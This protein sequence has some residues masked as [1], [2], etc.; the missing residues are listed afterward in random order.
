[1]TA[2]SILLLALV[3]LRLRESLPRESRSSM[4]PVYL[5][6]TYF[7]VS[8]HARF[9]LI[10]LSSSMFFGGF[11]L[12]I[13]SAPTMVYEH[14]GLGPNDFGYLFAMLVV[15]IM[16]GSRLS[17]QLAGI[18]NPR[19]QIGIGFGLM[20]LAALINLTLTRMLEPEL[21]T[22]MLPVTLYAIGMALLMPVFT[23]MALDCF[24]NNRGLASSMTGFLQMGGNALVAGFVT[25]LLY[26]SVSKLSAG[27]LGFV[28]LALVLYWGSVRV[29]AT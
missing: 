17:I 12:Y 2:L 8:S 6:K 16:I 1:L 24:P 22:T 23:I 18:W 25:P 7:R 19:Q 20:L 21:L 15:G 3:A 5:I 4:H 26:H 28:L 29:E 10:S 13:T 9:M 14:L 27:M 11:F